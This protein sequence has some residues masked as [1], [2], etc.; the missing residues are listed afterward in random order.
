[1]TSR[2]LPWAGM[3]RN[4]MRFDWRSCSTAGS[5]SRCGWVV[6]YTRSTC[7]RALCEELNVRVLVDIVAGTSAGG[8]NGTLLA[9]AVAAGRPLPSE[10]RDLWINEAAL[11]GDK[12]L[13]RDTPVASLL[14][15]R[16]LEEKIRTVT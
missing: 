11:T 3:E 9:S 12:L 2:R 13:R 5:V 10:L 15:G 14:S 8:L 7:W 16:F 6:S 1:M 4:A